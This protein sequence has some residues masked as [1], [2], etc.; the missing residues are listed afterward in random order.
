MNGLL[1]HHLQVVNSGFQYTE[2]CESESPFPSHRY[3]DNKAW[4]WLGKNIRDL[5]GPVLF[6]NIGAEVLNKENQRDVG[7]SSETAGSPRGR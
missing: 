7:E 4:D 6:W 1:G 5:K 2:A 3:Y